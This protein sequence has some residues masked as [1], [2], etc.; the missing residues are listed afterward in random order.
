VDVY[1]SAPLAL[2]QN[3]TR[4]CRR[5]SFTIRLLRFPYLYQIVSDC[6][7]A[8]DRIRLSWFFGLGG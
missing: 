2:A 5:I 8:I 3:P 7:S 1:W 4:S 6:Q